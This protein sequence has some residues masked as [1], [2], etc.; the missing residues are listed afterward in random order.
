[1]AQQSQPNGASV[2]LIRPAQI[3]TLPLSVS[4][5]Q[6]QQYKAGLAQLWQTLETS[7]Q[8]SPAYSE[9]EQKIRVASVK[10][11]QQISNRQGGARP[12][13]GGG[14]SGAGGGGAQAVAGQGAMAQNMQQQ[15]SQ[16]GQQQ[17]NVSPQIQGEL[18]AVGS[19]NV[20]QAVQQRGEQA[21]THYKREWMQR[22]ISILQRRENAKTKGS[23][24]Q[25]QSQ[26]GNN[27]PQIQ[28]EMVKCK[29]DMEQAHS[30]F[31]KLKTQNTQQGVALSLI[32]I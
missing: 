13:S 3:D 2:P 4:A 6:K 5:E 31:V 20:P 9:A 26:S 22:A 28:Q 16:Q 27:N 23:M 25:R 32:H 1:M 17:S 11:M 21:V 7:P 24:L 18:R 29:N 14:P 10:L 19:V 30:E 8:G 12:T 15:G